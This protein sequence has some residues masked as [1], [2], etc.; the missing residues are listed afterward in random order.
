MGKRR[1]IINAGGTLIINDSTISGNT[2]VTGAGI[3]TFGNGTLTL[4]NSLIVNNQAV[5]FG[6]GLD[7]F[8]GTIHIINSTISGNQTLEDENPGFDGGAAMTIYNFPSVTIINSTITA[9]VAHVPERS[10]IWVENTAITIQNSIVAGNG[11]SS[12]NCYLANGGA[13][14]DNGKNIDSGTTCG[15][16]AGSFSNTNPLLGAL[17]NNGGPTLTHL[18]ANTSPAVNAGNNALALDQNG[19]ALT[20]DQRGSGFPRI[21][22]GTVDIGAVEVILPTSN[23]LQA[24]LTL[25]GRTNPAPHASYVMTV[26]V[27]VLPQGG[28][29]PFISQDYVSNTSG[30][31][32]VSNLPVGT[33]LFSFKGTHT[34]ARQSVITI[35]AGSNSRTT[36]LLRE[37]DASD[38]NVVNISDFSILAAAFG[39]SVGG[40]AYDAR[41]NFNGDNAVTISDFSLLA[42]NFLQVGDGGVVP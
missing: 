28:G 3:T 31:F 38:N 5:D 33:Y 27:R 4:T 41:A 13:I 32:T 19:A 2:A 16:G 17:A 21:N 42:A 9:N 29:T 11:G 34:L 14:T 6:G 20:T 37:G 39:T 8:G 23:T 36:D 26:H 12:D 7:I 35:T 10:G 30:V 18:P 24:T 1:G 40:P 25:Q 15:F 22:S